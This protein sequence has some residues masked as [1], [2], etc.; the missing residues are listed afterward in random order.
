MSKSYDITDF[1]LK[2]LPL[3]QKGLVAIFADI[4]QILTRLIK[5]I[6]KESKKVGWKK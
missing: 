1:F 4:I 2:Y 6:F 3:F 5:T